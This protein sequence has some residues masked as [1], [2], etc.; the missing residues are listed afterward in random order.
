MESRGLQ[1]T[2][3]IWFF[4]LVVCVGLVLV[5]CSSGGGSEEVRPYGDTETSD[6]DEADDDDASPD[7]DDDDGEPSVGTSVGDRIPDFTYSNQDGS[8]TTLYDSEGKVIL[9]CC[10]ATW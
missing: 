5:S 2:L 1:L 3:W 4:A 8:S 9:L 6:D 10:A 7:G